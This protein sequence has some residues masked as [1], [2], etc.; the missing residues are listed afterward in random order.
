MKK[1]I[2]LS[3]VFL[4]G[5]A[6]V[7]YSAGFDAGLWEEKAFLHTEFQGVKEAN[8]FI[9]K[10]S[11]NANAYAGL[12]TLF[13]AFCLSGSDCDNGDNGGPLVAQNGHMQGHYNMGGLLLINDVVLSK[14]MNTEKF[15]VDLNLD[16]GRCP[17]CIKSDITSFTTE[18]GMHSTAWDVPMGALE[19]GKVSNYASGNA[20]TFSK[21]LKPFYREIIERYIGSSSL[22][23]LKE[24]EIGAYANAYLSLLPNPT[25][26]NASLIL[27]LEALSSSLI[28]NENY[29]NNFKKQTQNEADKIW[30]FSADGGEAAFVSSFYDD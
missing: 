26:V 1:V 18:G 7:S 14:S 11:F 19:N 27:N 20:I 16:G 13:G 25:S 10:E 22:K 4:L 12:G 17:N 3:L 24:Y 2:I 8:L 9:G 21:I 29:H 23:N 6:A 30:S 28:K 5:F 15:G